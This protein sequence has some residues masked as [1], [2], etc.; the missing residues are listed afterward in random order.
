M[1][2]QPVRDRVAREPP[3]DAVRHREGLRRRL[4]PRRLVHDRGLLAE[5]SEVDRSTPPSAAVTR[6]TS[7]M[8][9]TTLFPLSLE[10]RK[11]RLGPAVGARARQSNL[12][13]AA[14]LEAPSDVAWGVTSA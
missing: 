9:W 10:R 7:R 14:G 6:S 12:V 2:R 13:R 8:R 4:D 1:R 5:G 11:V 3:L